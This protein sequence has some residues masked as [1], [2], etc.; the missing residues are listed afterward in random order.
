[1]SAIAKSAR[2]IRFDE[3]LTLTGL[4]RPRIYQL[5]REDRFPR[6]VR[7]GVMSVAFV[8]AEV[9]AWIDDRIAARERDAI[10]Q[11]RPGASR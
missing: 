10:G 1:M 9:R 3:V 8:E 4:S 11:D 2:L 5:I 6:Q 7:L